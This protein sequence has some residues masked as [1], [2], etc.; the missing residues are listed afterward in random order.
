MVEGTVVRVETVELFETAR[1][2][3]DYFAAVC[4][5]CYA[6]NARERLVRQVCIW[7][8]GIKT[9]QLVP[10]YKEAGYCFWC[11]CKGFGGDIARFQP[12][13]IAG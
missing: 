1:W 11:G 8:L 10:V 2:L 13:V 4:C 7:A 3:V 6:L 5:V 9:F 12:A